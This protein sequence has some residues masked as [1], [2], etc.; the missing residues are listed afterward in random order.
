MTDPVASDAGAPL[1]APRLR[2]ESQAVSVVG[3]RREVWA[4]RIAIGGGWIIGQALLSVL[5]GPSSG[6]WGTLLGFSALALLLGSSDQNAVVVTRRGRRGSI[7]VED[8]VLRVEAGERTWTFPLAHI[9][10]GWTTASAGGERVVLETRTRS[11][12]AVDVPGAAASRELLHALG[13]GPDQRA[14]AMRVA[15][16]QSASSRFLLALGGLFF[17]SITMLLG[18][19]SVLLFWESL[20][21]SSAVGPGH[22]VASMLTL[23][24]GVGAWVCISPLT[25]TTVRIGTDGVS[26]QRF[27]RRR[28]IPRA[29][30]EGVG[31]SRGTLV[32]ERR[33]GRLLTV[34]TA[35]PEEALTLQRR[36]EEALAA[37]ESQAPA[38][39]LAALD[40][41][42]RPVDEWRRA[43]EA[44]IREGTGYRRAGIE[45]DDLLLVV[46]DGA[47]R[48]ERRVA[49]AVALASRGDPAARRRVRVAAEACVSPKLRIAIAQAAEG[50]IDED[51][52][53]AA[54]EEAALSRRGA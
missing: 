1:R 13:L 34:Q 29:Q 14:V 23:M 46:E 18:S 48:P 33:D 47:A 54:E 4:R 24:F 41:S 39:A 16:S 50:D 32:F 26:V 38:E 22:L 20:R 12:I 52:L 10:A 2:V 45:A 8:E 6:C 37:H 30:I 3:R 9:V 25:T 28:F 11:L 7:T 21:G 43:V 36:V 44:L 40:R 53:A 31:V 17:S 15:I 42:G 49:A 27:G 35:G 51:A 5:A 19:L